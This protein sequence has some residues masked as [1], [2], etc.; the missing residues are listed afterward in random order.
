MGLMLVFMDVL[1]GRS[2]KDE[3]P[4]HFIIGSATA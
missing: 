4:F 3:M 2:L 1:V